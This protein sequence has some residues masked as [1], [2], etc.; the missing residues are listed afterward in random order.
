MDES[1]INILNSVVANATPLVIAGIGETITERAGVVNLSLDGSLALAAMVG[2][3]T[4]LA[5]QS[6]IAGLIAAMIAGALVALI[7]AIA[8]IELKQDQVAVGFVL[9]LLAADLALFLG[10]D[11]T[12][13][14]GPQLLSVPLPVLK[15]IPVVGEIF[16]NHQ[17]LVYVSYILIFVTWYILF[18]T[19]A[20]LAHRAVGER[21][22]SAFARGTNV[23]RMRYFYTILGGALVG[24][25]GAAY[26]LAVKPGWS[27]PPVMR[28]D[29]WI[30]LAIVIFAG[31]HPFRVVL[32]AYLFAGLRALA[33]AIQRSPD[34][35]IPL[36]LLNGLPWLLMI[37]TLLL[38]SSGAVE[39]L[40][41]VMPR[42][43]QKSMR[44][45]LRSD[46]PAALGTRFDEG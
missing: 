4:A 24:L 16:F 34:I 44:S 8:G 37:V 13:T 11:Y 14:R 36:V 43:L 3:V 38:V 28:G 9:T 17:P 1:L 25:A 27:T 26:S 12:R 15:D 29:G 42:P 6:V 45:V 5:T 35:Q 33:S 40:L 10:Q 23:N 39:R 18:H 22:E 21:P 32:G 20:G 2:F 7:I 19:R 41:S 31:W 30:A 46:P